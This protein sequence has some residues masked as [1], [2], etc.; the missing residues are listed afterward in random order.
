MEIRKAQKEDIK[1]IYQMY[2]DGSESL[3]AEGVNQWQ[4]VEKPQLWEVEDN[5]N[6]IYVL[7]DKGA[8]A[9]ARIMDYD[10]AYDK[11]YEGSWLSNGKYYAIHKV[12][13]LN[14]K[15]RRGYAGKLLGEIEEF[16][17]KNGISSLKVDTHEDNKTMQN[18]LLS[19]GYKY[20]GIVY[21]EIE[22][23]RFAYEKI[24]G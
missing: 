19:L 14:S 22:G 6:Q 23:K 24:I 20:C 8:V 16:G 11:I 12:A 7:D 18:F 13:T 17:R 2:L 3:R 15:K 10:P 21:L 5:L 9:T 1:I 4:G